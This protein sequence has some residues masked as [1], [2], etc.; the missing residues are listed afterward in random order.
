MSVNFNSILGGFKDE[1]F[2]LTLTIVAVAQNGTD[3]GRTWRDLGTPTS[4]TFTINKNDNT[5]SVTPDSTTSSTTTHELQG[6]S[7]YWRV[8]FAGLAITNPKS[9]SNDGVYFLDKDGT[10]SEVSFE[11]Y[12]AFMRDIQKEQEA[13]EAEN[14]TEVK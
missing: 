14:I 5:Y 2:P 1:D 7:Y 10:F 3:S 11:E 8:R 9:R 13:R 4:N 12:R 6:T